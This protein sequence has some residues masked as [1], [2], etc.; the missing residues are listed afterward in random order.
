MGYDRNDRR[1]GRDYRYEGSDR[2]RSD[3]YDD[4]RERGFFDRAGD[5]IRSWFG[6]DEA[7]RRRRMDERY[8]ERQ[9]RDYGYGYG[10]REGR[11]AGQQRGGYRSPESYPRWRRSNR[12]YSGDWSPTSYHYTNLGA[13]EDSQFNDPPVRSWADTGYDYRSDRGRW[14]DEYRYGDRGRSRSGGS[15]DPHGYG[16]WRRRQLDQFDRDYDEYR[17]ENQSRFENEFGQWRQARQAQRDSLGSVQEHQEVVGS[18]GQHIGTVDH[19]RGDRIL[20]TKSDRDSGGHHH[21]IPSSWIDKVDDKVHVRKTAEEAKQAWR[22]E[23]RNQG[24]FGAERDDD[25]DY[26]RGG[27]LDRSFSGTYEDKR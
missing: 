17:R 6:D 21:L 1:S 4:P 10:S 3:R 14:E 20:L 16:S 11:Y 15:E 22:D 8:D 24:L 13:G 23:E 19:V 18:D 9:D 5:E 27:N 26:A 2:W 12:G 7:E 25:H